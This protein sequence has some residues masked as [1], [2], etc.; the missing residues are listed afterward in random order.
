MDPKISK[1]R[2]G[3]F[4]EASSIMDIHLGINP[5][6]GGSPPNDRI[7]RAKIILEFIDF[8]RLFMFVL[9]EDDR[10]FRSV[11]IG[12]IRREYMVKYR[13]DN[14]ILFIDSSPIIHPMWVIDE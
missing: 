6:R 7:S 12:I 5:V 11:K 13:K 2:S 8:I 9:Y 1:I 3:A 14:R 4:D 10:E